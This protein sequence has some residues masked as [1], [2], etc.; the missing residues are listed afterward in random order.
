MIFWYRVHTQLGA[1]LNFQNL[2]GLQTL[3][4]FKI[5]S[6]NFLKEAI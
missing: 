5:Q 1:E 3:Y 2:R 6:Y 4:S